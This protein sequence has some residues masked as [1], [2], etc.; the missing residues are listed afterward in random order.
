MLIR[1][2]KSDSLVLYSENSTFTFMDWWLCC[3]EGWSDEQQQEAFIKLLVD[4]AIRFHCMD[5]VYLAAY[6][7]R[8][9]WMEKSGEGLAILQHAILAQEK[10]RHERKEDEEQDDE[11]IDVSARKNEDNLPTSRALIK[12][13]DCFNR[14]YRLSCS[15][16][17]PL[18]A[19]LKGDDECLTCFLGIVQGYPILLDVSRSVE[20]DDHGTKSA[21]FGLYMGWL[22]GGDLVE[23]GRG[24][25]AFVMM[26][27]NARVWSSSKIAGDGSKWLQLFAMQAMRENFFRGHHLFFKDVAW[28]AVV[29]DGSPY[30]GP[31][32]DI[33]HLD[34]KL[35]LKE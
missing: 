16:S 35:M 10:A 33:M 6:A 2:L 27:A 20:E 18:C 12:H 15:I 4:D 17:R 26:G 3:Q 23:P 5:P 11:D 25:R 29:A 13:D 24:H 30:F 7:V 9:P 21:R 22:G 19:T 32:D 8:N 31:D 28:D 1:I 14:V 34:F